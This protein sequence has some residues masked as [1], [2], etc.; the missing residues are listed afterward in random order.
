MAAWVK[1]TDAQ[2]RT[3]FINLDVAISI[4]PLERTGLT[5]VAFIGA[6]KDTVEVKET[7]DYLIKTADSV[8]VA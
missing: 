4:V 5:R 1:C 2:E 7:P 6:D 8:R 3:I